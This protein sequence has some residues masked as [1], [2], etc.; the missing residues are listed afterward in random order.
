MYIVLCDYELD[1]KGKGSKSKNKK[2][3]LFQTEKFCTAK[4]IANKTKS[5]QVN[6]NVLKSRNQ[7]QQS[8]RTEKKCVLTGMDFVSY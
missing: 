3:R 8:Y 4:E 6:V 1:L 7:G 2:K 5:N